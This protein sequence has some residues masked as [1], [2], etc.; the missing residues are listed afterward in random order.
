MFKS[1]DKKFEEIGFVKTRENEYGATYEREDKKYKY[2]QVIEIMSK[3][4]GRHIFQSYQKDVNKD[5]FNNVVGL[6]S[7]ETKLVLKKMLKMGLKST[8]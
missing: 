8:R 3:D 5:G 7:Y 2:V 1:I 4:S 6:T